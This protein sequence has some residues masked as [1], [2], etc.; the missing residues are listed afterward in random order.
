MNRQVISIN[1]VINV[2]Q[3]RGERLVS[4]LVISLTNNR[5]TVHHA[6]LRSHDHAS[7]PTAC[8]TQNT[9]AQNLFGITP[10]STEK[11]CKF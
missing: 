9:S 7:T 1:L 4:D 10:E 11:T 6:I 5:L 3:L 8:I 2:K